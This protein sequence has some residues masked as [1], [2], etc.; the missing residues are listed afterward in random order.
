MIQNKKQY[1]FTL[2]ESQPHC[3]T[4]IKRFC[5]KVIF[6]QLL[7]SGVGAKTKISNFEGRLEI[8]S[9]LTI[10]LAK[11]DYLQPTLEYTCHKSHDLC[12]HHWIPAGHYREAADHNKEKVA[13]NVS[14]PVLKL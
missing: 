12:D 10:E 2:N 8:W 5:T 11:N 1:Y 9:F 13:E 7:L 3:R 6:Q 14:S 4:K